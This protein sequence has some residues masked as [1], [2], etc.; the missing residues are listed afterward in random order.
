MTAGIDLSGGLV[1]AVAV[2]G[3]GQVLARADRLPGVE[4][5]G[6]AVREAFNEV[7]T[8]SGSSHAG[9]AGVATHGPGDPLPEDI[10]SILAH[11]GAAGAVTLGSGAATA[12]GEAWC[13]AARGCHDVVAF[14][15]GQHVT[16]GVLVGGRV[17]RGAHGN[18]G[19]VGWMALNPVERADYRRYGGLEAEVG[20]AGI[21][22]RIVWRIKSGDQSSVADQVGGDLSRITADHVFNAARAGDGV[23]ISVVRDTVRYIAM[24]VSN[25]ATMFDPECVVLGGTVTEGGEEML[26]AIRVECCRRVRPAQAG[27]LRIVMSELGADSVAIGAARAALLQR[28]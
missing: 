28:Q 27:Q 9:V 23:S 21:V 19:V 8:T 2:T 13:G 18:A 1:H 26:D 20:A 16:A 22:R 6:A 11:E 3:E 14:A 10:V 4:G 17:L 24:T 7:R 12:L 25:L 15:L 5:V